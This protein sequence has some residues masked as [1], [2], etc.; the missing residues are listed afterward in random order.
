[1]VPIAHK[2]SSTLRL[3]ICTQTVDRN[4]PFLGFFHRWIEEF[5]K[6]CEQVNVICLKEGKHELPENVRV[7]SLGKE[8]AS[9]RRR[10]PAFAR[11]IRYTF[12]FL[13]LAWKL[14]REYDAV[15][16]HMNQEYVLLGGPLWR[17]W[18][19]PVA[20]WYTHKSVT[21][22][23]R[24]AVKMT[25]RIFTATPESFRISS[26]KVRIMGHGIELARVPKIPSAGS[27]LHIVTVGRISESK[28]VREMIGALDALAARGIDFTF[29][30][31][32]AS[33]TDAD[34][35]YAARMREEVSRRSYASAVRFVGAVPH[36]EL[37][38]Y[39]ARADVFLH[40]SDTGSMDKAMLEA[41]VAGVPVVT[42]NDA[43]KAI[44]PREYQ[45]DRGDPSDIA[46]AL[47]RAASSDISALS[48]R[49]AREHD[50]SDL[51]SRIVRDMEV[52][53]KRPPKRRA[54][55]M[56]LRFLLTMR[57]LLDPI[58]QFHEVSILCYHSISDADLDTAITPEAFELHLRVIKQSGAAFVP[59][60]RV[61][62][63]QRGEATLPR[64]AVAITFDDGY[65]DFLTTALPILE[66]YE[67][68]VTL[69]AVGDN[70]G[71]RAQLGND[72]ALLTPG[73]M[74]SLRGNPHVE[75]GYHG[76]THLNMA[77]IG[78]GQM[79]SEIAPRYGARFFAYPG[80]NYSDAAIDAVRG[81]GYAAACS[82]KRGLVVGWDNQHFLP[83][84]VISRDTPVWMIRAYTTN[85]IAWYRLLRT[86]AKT[87][88]YE[89]HDH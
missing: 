61:V 29:D 89:S 35:V 8:S 2:K 82:I 87:T 85:A 10:I 51:I 84:A 18:G 48:A 33:A 30:F 70:E 66:A 72:L 53:V 46:D 83:R 3:L 23:L 37:A 79:L 75:I 54:P 59:L 40:L 43:G 34:E 21:R 5:A 17:L 55:R 42:S 74:E 52:I 47:S 80:G 13:A 16:V 12:R 41:L 6:R 67:A 73:E 63:W 60:E 7:H 86:Y 14:R 64:R 44:V 4:D 81:A 56:F 77:R 32:G 78:R 50:L 38:A 26:P 69:F 1:M 76:L 57:D 36:G 88:P 28:G 15:F 58:F 19:K 31:V 25:S 39:L 49:I 68:P 71:S 9:W 20:L 22:T 24:A 62:A 65:R 27:A 11:R 45:V